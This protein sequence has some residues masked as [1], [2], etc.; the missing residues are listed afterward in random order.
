MLTDTGKTIV[1]GLLVVILIIVLLSIF[2][3]T[4]QE[5]D[6][7]KLY[8]QSHIS[9][10]SVVITGKVNVRSEPIVVNTEDGGNSYGRKK[11]DGAITIPVVGVVAENA[12][13]H[14]LD[15]NNGAFIGVYVDDIT[16]VKGWRKIFPS[17]IKKDPDGI[18]WFHCDYIHYN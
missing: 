7:S 4:P 6:F 3:K 5:Y 11:T 18:V 8:T 14:H 12:G 1:R 17:S 15:R 2:H 13:G 16:D 10:T 9:A